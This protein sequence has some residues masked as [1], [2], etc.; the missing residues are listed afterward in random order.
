M[1]LPAA[2]PTDCGSLG[3]IPAGRI[4]QSTTGRVDQQTSEDATRFH[5]P[6]TPLSSRDPGYPGPLSQNRT[7]AGHIRLFGTAGYEPHCRPGYDLAYPHCSSS[8]LGAVLGN[9]DIRHRSATGTRPRSKKYRFRIV[10][11]TTG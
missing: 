8:C 3:L 10:L 6:R 5:V 11:L 9:R 4:L 2:P 1:S 7:C